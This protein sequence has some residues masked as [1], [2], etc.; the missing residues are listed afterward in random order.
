MLMVGAYEANKMSKFIE[1]KG[2][3]T[4]SLAHNYN[5]LRFI[6]LQIHFRLSNP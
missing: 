3:S 2:V 6:K 5:S 1:K 4:V